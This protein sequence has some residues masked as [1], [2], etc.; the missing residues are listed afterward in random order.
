MAIID[1]LNKA[2]LKLSV[3]QWQ[4]DKQSNYQLKGLSGSSKALLVAER[5]LQEHQHCLCILNDKEEAAYFFNDLKSSLDAKQVLFFPYSY[6][7][8]FKEQKQD[9]SSIILR[10]EVL[11]QLSRSTKKYCI[12][13]YPEA[14][15]EKVSKKK[16]LNDQRLSLKVGKDY[17]LQE[18]NVTLE[19][20]KFERVDFVYEPGQYAIRGHLLDIFSYN[21]EE[22]YRIQF[23]DNEIEAIKTFDVE[24][25]LSKQEKKQISILPNCS[26]DAPEH[27]TSF[28][29]FLPDN[30]LVFAESIAFVLEKNKQL[31]EEYEKGNQ[32][33]NILETETLEEDLSR[34]Q[35]YVW[36]ALDR[37][38]S[39]EQKQCSITPQPA[40]NKNF[41]LLIQDLK[42]K[43]Q[44]GYQVF[45]LSENTQ[46]I[47]RL[48]HILESH[49]LKVNLDTVDINLHEGFIDNVGRFAIYTDHQIFD[50]YHKHRLKT[51]FG[52]QA[53]ITLKEI[54]EL[55]PGDYVV[56]Q[57]HG[58]GQFVGLQTIEVN[59][60]LQESI[61]LTYKDNDALFV[62]IHSLHRISKYKGKEGQAP[63]IYKLGSGA[64][65]K[66]KA[67]AKKKVKDIA[68]DLIALY[69]KRLQQKG[70]AYAPDNFMQE[71]LE[72]SFLYEDTPDQYKATVAVKED[73]QKEAPM[74]RLV[75]G[76]VGFGKTEIAIRAAFKAALEG[77]QTAILVPTTILAF[78][79]YNTFS[80]RM[81]DW[82]VTVEYISRMRTAKEVSD[83]KKRL[84]EGQIDII[85]GTHKLVG[86]NIKFNDLGLL[87]VDE[88]QKFGVAIKEK[89]KQMKVNVDTLT[90]TATPIPRTLQFSLMGARDL[91]VINTPPPN[92]HPI[93]TELHT[94]SE[95]VIKEA[96]E[97]EVGR[98]G[99]V[100]FIHNRV[101]N[102]Y[103][104]QKM[105]HRICPK[106]NAVVA[107]GQM[108]GKELEKIMLD[109]I[110]GAYGV[111]I[112]TTIIES[113]LD[114]PNANTIIVNNA[115]YFGLSTLHQLRGRV[116]RSNKKAFA[117]FL[118]PDPI[119]LTDEARRRL[120]ALED[121][122]ELGS[123]FNISLQDL[124]IRGA[125]DVLGGEQSG[126]IA[127]IG[128]ETYQKI[129][130]EAVTELKQQ[131]F[132]T[133]FEE[134]EAK[135]Q[136]PIEEMTFVNDCN[137]D[138]DLELRF[139]DT[140]IQNIPERM[141]LYRQLDN[142]EDEETLRLF[143]RNLEDRFG[144]LPPSAQELVEVIRLRRK[145]LAMGIERVSIKKNILKLYFIE[146]QDS[147]YYQ[148]D[149][150]GSVLS[151]IQKNT[152]IAE[153]KEV[154]SKLILRIKDV[155]SIYQAIQVLE[156][157]C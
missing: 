6:K 70:Y 131:E 85:V 46:Q 19:N 42:E 38:Q 7:R 117:Y 126:F 144:A 8:T 52:K 66:T 128:L 1:I 151:W 48:E 110:D 14:L 5:F 146:D 89:L 29:S 40:F 44:E 18:L 111:L 118:A 54:N 43:E 69:A 72:A 140:Y 79:H 61:R 98:G 150:F 156:Q 51:K 87:I 97:Y 73:M 94:F 119:S 100:F 124:D 36:G 133:V 74:D 26:L 152:A 91:S 2:N 86:K 129:L 63:K 15:V 58:I 99:Q 57:D 37:N 90:L 106:V 71:E 108:D 75:C 39:F 9:A 10:T 45:I 141:K 127:D 13:T 76:D 34:F 20:L 77:K 4:F 65:Q 113:G 41:D 121:F 67:K 16:Q 81:K 35:Q 47:K 155:K 12:V 101:Q 125:G 102:I 137:I 50:R 120:K 68:K 149:K 60:Q 139:P 49:S 23:F 24:N 21:S 157:I 153:L 33:N 122:S 147:L 3:S 11:E 56:H 64:W 115:N 95:S 31:V 84:A 134:Q 138:T 88:E 148:T 104:V 112:A 116:G 136:V 114:I 32:Q 17:A 96:I 62:S 145:A 132:K 130:Q 93:Q 103:E 105:I 109:F 143:V 25:Q 28:F 107:H 55:Q 154:K 123:G 92:R 135:S 83:I 80:S 30:S 82:P 53:A 27:Q 59:G 78:Q 22:P 142:I